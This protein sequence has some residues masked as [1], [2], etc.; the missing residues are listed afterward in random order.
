[1]H[2]GDA[3]PNDTVPPRRHKNESNDSASVAAGEEF[4]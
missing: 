4:Q 3:I 2:S 1:M